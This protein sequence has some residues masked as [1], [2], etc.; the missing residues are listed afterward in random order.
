MGSGKPGRYIWFLTEKS[1]PDTIGNKATNLRWLAQKGFSVPRTWVIRW[2]AFERYAQKDLAV[3]EAITKELAVF[4]DEEAAFAVR[5]SANLEDSLEH[6]FAGQFKTVLGV[7]GL[8]AILEAITTVWDSAHSPAVQAYLAKLPPRQRSLRMGVILQQMISPVV[9]GVS[10]SRNPITGDDEVIVEAVPGMGTALV[11]DGVTPLRWVSQENQWK[12]NPLEAPVANEVIAQVVAQTRR[13]AQLFRKDVDL[14]W[15]YDGQELFWVQ[16]RE[17]TSLKN[18]TI[19]SNRISKELLPGMIKPLIW[20][21]NN[22]LVVK[23]WVDLL[24]EMVGK[25]DLNLDDMAKCFYYRA[26]FNLTALGRIWEILG[27]PRE[28]LEMTMGVLPPQEGRRRF[29]LSRRMLSLLP[30]LA[31]FLWNKWKLGN[32]FMQEYPL[33]V[34]T[35]ERYEWRN[36]AGLSETELLV[37]ID[38][39]YTDTQRL[40]YFNINVPILMMLYNTLLG[41]LLKKVGVDLVTFDL[42]EGMAEHLDFDPLVA[43]QELRQVYAGLDP[44]LREHISHCSYTEFQAL[45]G[46]PNFQLSVA[47]FIQRF[48]HLSDSGNDFS[49]VPWRE[50]PEVV[51]KLVSQSITPPESAAV[52]VRL[53][54]IKLK[55]LQK[56]WTHL[57]YRRAR[58]FRLHREQVSSLYTYA[59]GLFRPYFLA[60]GKRFSAHGALKDPADIFYLSL[61]EVREMAGGSF[62]QDVQQMVEDRKKEMEQCCNIL[63]PN[64]IYGDTAPVLQAQAAEK[65]TGVP[66]SR[67]FYSGPAK[68]VRGLDDFHK[69][70]SGDVLVIPYSDVGWTPLFAHAGAVVAESGGMLSHSAIVAR[71]YR[72][73]AVVSV[74]GAM[75]LADHTHLTVDGYRGEVIL[76]SLPSLQGAVNA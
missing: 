45:Q 60:L 19:Y 76:G 25:N 34:S 56:Y 49:A 18:L 37:E 13:A 73:P 74:A 22:P 10:F 43:L 69:V 2:E 17:I 50:K 8:K 1:L 40:V 36:T 68:V 39:L 57:M 46:I 70:K 26:Y 55:G 9:S 6:S 59:Y 65:L 24:T 72:I 42:M 30:R 53:G 31:G 7:Q 64:L 47:Y 32:R 29:K 21:V 28:I 5:S 41:R 66:A 15:V 35:F 27:M 71:E 58:Q 23:V 3:I 63:L 12:K 4:L 67:G 51:L 62:D 61:D 54:E 52:K 75:Q 20:S 38:R 14:E 44:A 11:Q 33:L 16:L 48:G